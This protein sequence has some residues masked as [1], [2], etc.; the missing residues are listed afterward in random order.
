MAAILNP[1]KG[2]G[3]KIVVRHSIRMTKFLESLKAKK[4]H[5][6]TDVGKFL[7]TELLDCD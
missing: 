2:S 6:Q 1:F 7:S 5:S 3:G 4:I